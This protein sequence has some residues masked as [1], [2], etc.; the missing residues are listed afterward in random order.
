MVKKMHMDRINLN[1]LNEK[2]VKEQYQIK[3]KNKFAALKNLNDNGDISR[4]WDTITENIKLSAKDS[5]GHYESKYH[6]PWFDE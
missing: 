2:E 1:K 4:V 6:K 5:I 3:I